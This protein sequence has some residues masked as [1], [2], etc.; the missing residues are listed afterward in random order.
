MLQTIYPDAIS[1]S[2]KTGF[3]LDEFSQAVVA[4]Y[5]GDIAMVRVTYTH[6]NGKVTNYLRS[7]GKILDTKYDEN[8]VITEVKL[9][10]NQLP[11]LYHLHP[12]NV[13][14]IED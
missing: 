5:K 14:I 3:G 12:D 13:E 9:G 1:I 2:A 7:Q 8:L 11:E 10:K 6:T 4:R